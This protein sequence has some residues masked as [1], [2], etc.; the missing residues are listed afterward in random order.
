MARAVVK[1]QRCAAEAV[2]DVT[3]RC[4]N[5]QSR[6]AARELN[7]DVVTADASLSSSARLTARDRIQRRI[8]CVEGDAGTDV[9]PLEWVRVAGM[10]RRLSAA[11]AACRT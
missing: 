9:V 7:R 11:L 10:I 3:L 8:E 4:I 5:C 1:R 6:R 2:A